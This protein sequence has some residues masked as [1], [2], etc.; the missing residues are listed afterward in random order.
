[1]VWRLC[2]HMNRRLWFALFLAP[3]GVRAE[4]VTVVLNTELGEIVLELFPQ[5]APKTAANFLRYLDAGSYNGGFFHR[6]V[7]PENQPENTVKIEVIQAGV[8]PE[9]RDELIA[10]VALERTSLTG[11]RHLDGTVSMA[12]TAPDSARTEFFI[13]I[14][15]QPE[16]DFGGRRN[17]DGQGFAAFGKVTRGMDVVRRIQQA[18]AEAQRLTPPV[19]ILKASR[20]P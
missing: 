19:R 17:P 11:Q 10:P 9:K 20:R 13:C 14:G 8:N 15:N 2:E 16:L 7:K 5:Q 3:L 18:P 6:T 4:T 12:R 1:M